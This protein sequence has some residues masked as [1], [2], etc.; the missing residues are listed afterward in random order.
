MRFEP[1]FKTKDDLKTYFLTD[2]LMAEYFSSA[3]RVVRTE[4]FLISN[5]DL[6][7][8]PQCFQLKCGN[9]R[10]V[11]FEDVWNG[12]IYD[13]LRSALAEDLS[14]VCVHCCSNRVEKDQ[15][16]VSTTIPGE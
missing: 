1:D 14:P 9:I 12:P 6:M 2:N 8:A 5:G 13:R 7:F 3:C 10:D 11:N 16:A 4:I 15:D